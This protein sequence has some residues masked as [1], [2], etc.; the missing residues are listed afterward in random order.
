MNTGKLTSENKAALEQL[1]N[2]GA[3]KGGDTYS[4]A[5]Q[6]LSFDEQA[7]YT[8]AQLNAS[9]AETLKNAIVRQGR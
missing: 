2:G 3:E 6:L 1:I 7:D 4:E 5:E 9:A 8:S